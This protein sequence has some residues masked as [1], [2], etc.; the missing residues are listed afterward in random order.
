MPFIPSACFASK[1]WSSTSLTVRPRET[2][3]PERRRLPSTSCLFGLFT[4]EDPDPIG[5]EQVVSL[6]KLYLDP[7]TG[8][9]SRGGKPSTATPA[10][11]PPPPIAKSQAGAD[12]LPFW[13]IGSGKGGPAVAGR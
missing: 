10:R 13:S 12:D 3:P 1:Y 7:V 4:G 2:G 9:R 6:A 8:R 11:S 5:R